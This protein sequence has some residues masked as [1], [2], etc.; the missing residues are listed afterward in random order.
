MSLR[1]H[2]LVKLTVVVVLVSS[3]LF[4]KLPTAA[5]LYINSL[6]R[7]INKRG[8]AWYHSRAM[9]ALDGE[10]FVVFHQDGKQLEARMILDAAEGFYPALAENFGFEIPGPIPVLLYTDREGL[11]RS[12]GWPADANTVGVYWAG[13]IRVLSPDVWIDP[14]EEEQDYY[15]AFVDLGPM[16]HEIVHLFVD[17][18][19]RGNCPRWFNE[20]VAQYQ[21]YLLT[22]FHFGEARFFPLENAYTFAELADF[23]SLED[24][25]LAYH[26][27][28]SI[29]TF[30]VESYGWPAVIRVLDAF[31]R[32]ASL[33][34]A[35]EQ[36]LDLDLN[37]LD[38]EWKRWV[39]HMQE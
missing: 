35:L 28:F 8:L 12:F 16:A 31:G 13:S 30:L 20:G 39:A 27:S 26:Q 23:D 19:T 1:I 17:Y 11:N 29:M 18:L 2:F 25:N 36:V 37:T 7:E 15:Q 24:Q 10:R 34:E 38:G 9:N 33:E 21:E 4:T 5:T 3:I 32:G 14:E 6:I 22:G